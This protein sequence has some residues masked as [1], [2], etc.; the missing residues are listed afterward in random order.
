M[1]CTVGFGSDGAPATHTATESQKVSE[2][3]S[4]GRGR[5]VKSSLPGLLIATGTEVKKKKK[6]RSKEKA[7]SPRC[8]PQ[9]A[10]AET[11]EH[12]TVK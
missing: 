11:Q 8:D 5:T 12:R 9:P 4:A 2:G 6:G 10:A 1:S 7:R 3:K